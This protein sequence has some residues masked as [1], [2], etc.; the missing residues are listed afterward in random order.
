ML[1]LTI[2]IVKA[3]PFDNILYFCCFH[4]FQLFCFFKKNNICACSLKFSHKYR[5]LIIICP[6]LPLGGLSQHTSLL[7]LCPLFYTFYPPTFNSMN[8]LRAAL[9]C[10]SVGP[11]KGIINTQVTTSSK[12]SDFTSARKPQLPIISQLVTGVTRA[13]PTSML[14]VLTGL[15]PCKSCVGNHGCYVVTCVAM[16]Y[17]EEGILKIFSPFPSSYSL[18]IYYAGQSLSLG[19]C[20]RNQLIDNLQLYI[21]S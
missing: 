3:E 18:P 7:R 2:E 8:P 13:S 14:E 1:N 9:V 4:V 21:H 20:G 5:I 10:T 6:L 15:I 16:S 19:I 17:P 11:L 12:K